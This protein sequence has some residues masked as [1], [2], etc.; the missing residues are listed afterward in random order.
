MQRQEDN[1]FNPYLQ[2]VNE[3]LSQKLIIIKTVTKVWRPLFE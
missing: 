3:T 1:E 2:K